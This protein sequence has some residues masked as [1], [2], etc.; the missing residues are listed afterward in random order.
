VYFVTGL[1]YVIQQPPNARLAKIKEEDIT[2]QSSHSCSSHWLRTR[3]L[4]QVVYLLDSNFVIVAFHIVSLDQCVPVYSVHCR[5]D[6]VPRAIL[7]TLKE[8]RGRWMSICLSREGGTWGQG[9][10][11]P[12]PSR[13]WLIS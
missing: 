1:S 11:C 3:A 2:N 7:I 9:G 13:F 10:I 6:V 8:R 12:P 4:Y 5:I